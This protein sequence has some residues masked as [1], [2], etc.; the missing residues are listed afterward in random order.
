VP[1]HRLEAIE[2]D[3]R[4]VVGSIRRFAQPVLDAPYLKINRLTDTGRMAGR[5]TM[6]AER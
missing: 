5:G 1:T 3:P 2:V 6:K 4:R